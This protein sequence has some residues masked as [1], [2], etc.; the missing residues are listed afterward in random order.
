[1]QNDHLERLRQAYPPGTRIELTGTITDTTDMSEGLQGTVEQV[2]DAGNLLMAW[3]NGRTV[4]LIPEKDQHKII[5]TP[6]Q[7]TEEGHGM[8]GPA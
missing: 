5:F 1:M 4:N 7:A 8:N 2:D 6:E 3:D